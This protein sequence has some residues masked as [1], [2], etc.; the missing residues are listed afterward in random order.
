MIFCGLPMFIIEQIPMRLKPKCDILALGADTRQRVSFSKAGKVFDVR[1]K[2]DFA[3]S[4]DFY[5]EVAS[6]LCGKVKTGFSVVS[7]DPHPLFVCNTLAAIIKKKY[8]P[9]AELVPVWHHIAHVASF[10]FEAGLNKNFIGVAFDGTGYGQD[11]R[12]WGGEFFIY[13][14]RK[15]SRTA[16]FCYQ[17]LCG[18]ELAIKEPWRFA[19]GVLYRIYGLKD[20]PGDIECFQSIK[21]STFK[22]LA[23]MVDKNF[24]TP[25]VSS[26]GRLFDAVGALLNLRAVAAKEAEAAIAVEE[27]AAGY[28]GGPVEP[29]DF[30]IL[31]EKDSF[32]VDPALMFKQIVRDA[33]LKAPVEK[34][35]YR[36]HITLAEMTRRV[37]VLLSRKYN[38][39]NV[40]FS[41][42][43]FMNHILTR[44]V[45][46]LMKEEKLD[47][48]FAPRPFN[49][50][51]GI[52]RGQI[53]ACSM[54]KLCV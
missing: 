19:F 36:F 47:S 12:V 40:Y 23:E 50:D 48:F 24:N 32:R 18:N 6:F 33:R 10:G 27:A 15:F 8:F 26:V 25:Q 21:N 7:F 4:E 20:F 3:C 11:H 2:S 5:Q 28:A 30:K 41:G 49:T 22:T 17:P 45:K 52:A 14:G 53:A 13:K 34:I 43:V 51:S 39:K 38:I 29:Y 31:K 46:G 16:H 35:A 54:E 44:Q 37:C 9:K 1:P 42:G